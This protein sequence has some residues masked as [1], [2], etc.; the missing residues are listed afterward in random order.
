MINIDNLIRMYRFLIIF[1]V[2][3]PIIHQQH[4]DSFL[5]VI[6]HVLNICTLCIT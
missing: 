4:Y 3:I 1:S 5:S 2:E 6:V